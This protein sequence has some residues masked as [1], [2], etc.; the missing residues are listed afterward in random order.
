MLIVLLFFAFYAGKFVIRVAPG[1]KTYHG[2]R[3]F[4]N[5]TSVAG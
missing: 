2:K 3:L 5:S 4:V 1:M